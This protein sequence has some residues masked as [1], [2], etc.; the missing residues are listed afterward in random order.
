M[1]IPQ[2]SLADI[3]AIPWRG[4]RM[5]FRPYATKSWTCAHCDH[6]APMDRSLAAVEGAGMRL[7]MACPRCSKPSII[8]IRGLFRIRVETE[9]VPPPEFFAGFEDLPR[10][11]PNTVPTAPAPWACQDHTAS[12]GESAS[13][14]CASS[15]EASTTPSEPV[16]VDDKTAMQQAAVSVHI[17][18][19]ALNPRAQA[20]LFVRCVR[21]RVPEDRSH[22]LFDLNVGMIWVVVN[23]YVAMEAGLP[24]IEWDR[25]HDDL[26]RKGN[27]AGVTSTEWSACYDMVVA[28]LHEVVKE[29]QSQPQDYDSIFLRHI[30][31]SVAE[32]PH[33]GAAK[34]ILDN[35]VARMQRYVK[36]DRRSWREIRQLESDLADR[37]YID[38]CADMPDIVHDVQDARGDSKA[39]VA[40]AVRL[41]LDAMRV[42][43]TL[44]GSR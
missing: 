23:Y 9:A 3:A 6:L 18:R 41:V 4:V 2:W 10:A 33:D 42:V 34:L 24:I 35:A 16:S 26:K 28:R 36:A 40:G 29:W 19:I 17:G 27:L 31:L 5:D 25:A 37:F 38:V 22:G 43:E 21:R 13:Q 11:S 39:I 30:D 44:G 7:V 1:L 32:S 20:R 12:H 8:R 14:D 15:D